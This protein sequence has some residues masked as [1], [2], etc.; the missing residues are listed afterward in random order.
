MA[1]DNGI[2]WFDSED[3]HNRRRC[4]R[5][6]PSALARGI[7]YVLFARRSDPNDMWPPLQSAFTQPVDL[8]TARSFAAGYGASWS[9]DDPAD[10]PDDPDTYVTVNLNEPQLRMLRGIVSSLVYFSPTDKNLTELAVQLCRHL[11]VV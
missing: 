5:W 7:G 4:V 3:N 9:D 10:T 8:D 2:T 1:R 11:R 6:Q